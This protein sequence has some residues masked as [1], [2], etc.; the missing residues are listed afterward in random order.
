MTFSVI[1]PVHN[2][3]KTIERCVDSLVHQDA[4]TQIILVEN[5]SEDDSYRLCR[6]LAEKHR[7]VETYICGST[8]VSAARN[9]GLLQ[10]R[11]DVIGFCDADDYYETD[12]LGAVADAFDRTAA[13]LH[14][15][16]FYL[17]GSGGKK[18]I[19]AEREEDI[20]VSKAID[21]YN[22]HPGIRGS[23]WNKFFRQELKP[24]MHFPED[25]THLEDGYMNAGVLTSRRETKIHVSRICTY[26]YV[27]N[28]EGASRD[29]QKCFAENGRLKYNIALHRMIDEMTLTKGEKSSIREQICRISTEYLYQDGDRLSGEM[30]AML[31]EEIRKTWLNYAARIFRYGSSHRIKYAIKGAL[32]LAGLIRR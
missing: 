1:V 20:S 8:G 18:L 7:Q 28:A 11:G 27:K 12:C 10:A 31:R 2:A 9:L 25:L 3:E 29:L 30:K 16:A 4:E 23:V 6:E 24:F 17:V 19:A 21:Y 13:D 15:T 22:N 26:N 32:I 14:I 5:G